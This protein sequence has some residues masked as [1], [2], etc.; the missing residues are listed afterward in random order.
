MKNKKE[1]W[2]PI[3][4]VGNNRYSYEVSNYGKIRMTG[5]NAKPLKLYIDSDG[6][7]TYKFN[8]KRHKV[9]RVVYEYFGLN[10]NPKYHVHHKDGNKLNNFI[11]NLECVSPSEHNK[12]HHKDNTFKNYKRGYVLSNKEKEEIFQKFKPYKYTKRMLATE[13]NISIATISRIIKE[14]K[15]KY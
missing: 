14:F 10:F 2:K 1:I 9:H 8:Y 3:K 15:E 11:D 4:K 7:A 12:I 6:Y 13:Y 5:E